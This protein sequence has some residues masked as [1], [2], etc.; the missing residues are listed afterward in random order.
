MGRVGC[1]GRGWGWVILVIWMNSRSHGGRTETTG[2]QKVSGRKTGEAGRKRPPGD[3]LS[4]GHCAGWPSCRLSMQ[5]NSHNNGFHSQNTFSKPATERFGTSV[6]C[7]YVLSVSTWDTEGK[8]ETQRARQ[9]PSG[10][11]TASKWLTLHSSEA[12]PKTRI[13]V[14]SC[15]LQVIY[16]RADSRKHPKGSREWVGKGQKGHSAL[17]NNHRGQMELNPASETQETRNKKLMP[18]SD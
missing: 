4:G 14:K 17:L 1:P 9:S 8:W 11:H 7:C 13:Q 5:G 10:S 12:D 15:T 3:S 2:A 6:Q 16:L 18:S